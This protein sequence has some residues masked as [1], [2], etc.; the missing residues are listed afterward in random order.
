MT[1]VDRSHTVGRARCVR[2]DDIALRVVG[3]VVH[4]HHHRRVDSLPGC[5]QH[6]SPGAGSQVGGS[7]GAGAELPILHHHVD[8]VLAPSEFSGF[9]SRRD[10]HLAVPDKQ[11]VLVES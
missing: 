11:D 6:D 2:Y 7:G 3:L 9:A 1:S 8:G 5:R 4:T 10:C